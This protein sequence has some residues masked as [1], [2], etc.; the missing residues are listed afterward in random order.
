MEFNYPYIRF[1]SFLTKAARFVQLGPAPAQANRYLL[2]GTE[3]KITQAN[4]DS[5]H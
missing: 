4:G 3:L 2:R 5:K 1:M